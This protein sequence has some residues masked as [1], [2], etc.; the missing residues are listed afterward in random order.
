MT[1]K[2]KKTFL[3]YCGTPKSGSTWIYQYL[4]QHPSCE[5]PPEKEL[6]VLDRI[7]FPKDFDK[8]NRYKMNRLGAMNENL[9]NEASEQKRLLMRKTIA[10]MFQEFSIVY[11]LE[12]YPFFFKRLLNTRE[13][14]A[15]LTGDLSPSYAYLERNELGKIKVLMEDAGFEIKIL[16]A[17][18]DPVQRIYSH[19]RML[20]RMNNAIFSLGEAGKAFK[21]AKSSFR[22]FF[23]HPFLERC[24][25]YDVCIENI[26]SSFSRDQ[27]HYIFYEEFFCTNEVK[28]LCE[29]LE[30]KFKTPDLD[31]FV[32]KTEKNLSLADDDKVAAMQYYRKTYGFVLGK[33]GHERVKKIWP[34]LPDKLMTKGVSK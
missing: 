5:M 32:N 19:L 10:Q 29:F 33:F 16:F 4:C 7:F 31:T 24:T 6:H 26:E 13:K 14:K 2:S 21:D 30:I 1:G 20:E 22:D 15:Q 23:N 34:E 28:K 9:K 18:R 25:R 27:I 8:W 3:L 11:D 17:M 12:I